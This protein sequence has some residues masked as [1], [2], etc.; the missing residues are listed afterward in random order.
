LPRAHISYVR[1][2]KEGLPLFLFNY[3]DHKLYGI[4]EA[5]GSGKFCPESNAWKNDGQGKTSFPAQ[6]KS[7]V[8]AFMNAIF[9]LI[10]SEN[11]YACKC[12]FVYLGCHAG[13]GV[14]FSASRESVQK[15]Y[16]SQLLSEH[17]QCPWPE[18][19]FFSV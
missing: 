4:Y 9:L 5:A 3:D 6:V 15:C 18:A 14:V 11:L 10:L 8:F 7:L 1:N 16:C 12:P 17:A 13:K 2:I 19:S